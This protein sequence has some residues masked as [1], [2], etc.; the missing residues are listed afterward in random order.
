M[1][2]LHIRKHVPTGSNTSSSFTSLTTSE[3]L[4]PL[5][6]FR[7]FFRNRNVVVLRHNMLLNAK[8]VTVILKNI[9]KDQD[10]GPVSQTDSDI[11]RSIYNS[12]TC[13]DIWRRQLC[14]T[15]FDILHALRKKCFKKCT[16][17]FRCVC[18]TLFLKSVQNLWTDFHQLWYQTAS[19]RFSSQFQCWS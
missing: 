16:S 7:K 13:S 6:Y 11:W 9:P 17:S 3:K 5:F 1:D 18:L 14:F 8:L 2:L 15:N 4:P 19:V 10:G 12:Q